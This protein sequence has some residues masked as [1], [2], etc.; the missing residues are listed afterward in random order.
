MGIAPLCI[1]ST[2]STYHDGVCSVHGNN[3]APNSD[4][5]MHQYA[6]IIMLAASV[7]LC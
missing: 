4:L 6:G 1:P 5:T 7:V 3:I 2:M